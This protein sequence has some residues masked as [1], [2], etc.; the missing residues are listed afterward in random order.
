MDLQWEGK[1]WRLFSMFL[2]IDHPNRVILLA[3]AWGCIPSQRC[4]FWFIAVDLLCYIYDMRE[5]QTDSRVIL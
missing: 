1:R 4:Q 3:I 2:T 5:G